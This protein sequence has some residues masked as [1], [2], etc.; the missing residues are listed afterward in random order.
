[1]FQTVYGVGYYLT[2]VKAK[3]RP[4]EGKGDGSG[5][6]ENFQG[7]VTSRPSTGDSV[8]D[9]IEDEGIS[10]ISTN[11]NI[12]NPSEGNERWTSLIQGLKFLSI[13]PNCSGSLCIR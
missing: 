6:E 3:A 10:D 11:D 8:L 9:D 2:L 13:F 1:M 12:I 7:L 5:L 4:G